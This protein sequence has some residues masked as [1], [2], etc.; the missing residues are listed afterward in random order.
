MGTIERDHVT[1][2]LAYL[3]RSWWKEFKSIERPLDLLKLLY[4]LHVESNVILRILLR[5]PFSVVEVQVVWHAA[6]VTNA[7]ISTENEAVK[8]GSFGS[9]SLLLACGGRLNRLK[10]GLR[11]CS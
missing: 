9:E 8:K 11:T 7:Q 6:T 5:G 4:E 1:I 10:H 3:V 2:D